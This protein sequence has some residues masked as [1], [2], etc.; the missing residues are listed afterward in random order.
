MPAECREQRAESTGGS[1]QRRRQG[2]VSFNGRAAE[3]SSSSSSFISI[4]NKLFIFWQ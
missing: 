2:H 1:R 4:I 3:S